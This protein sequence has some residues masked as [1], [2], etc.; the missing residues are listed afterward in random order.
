VRA[1]Q[2][3]AVINLLGAVLL[4]RAAPPTGGG[5]CMLSDGDGASTTHDTGPAK[6]WQGLLLPT[7]VASRFVNTTKNVL[8]KKSC[9][10]V[11][12]KSST[13]NPK[14]IFSRFFFSRFWAFLDEGSSKT[15]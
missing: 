11:F 3:K 8:Q 2:T 13:K 10:K 14:P 4:C 5:V 9:R 12:T 1:E 6:V 15:R 7:Q